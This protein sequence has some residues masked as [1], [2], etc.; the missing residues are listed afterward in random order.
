VRKLLSVRWLTA[1]LLIVLLSI[2]CVQLGR[3]QLHRLDERKA[4]NEVTRAN[5]AAPPV[6]VTEVVGPDRVVGAAHDWRT[7]VA[8]GR[9]DET[10]QIVIRYRNV[11]DRP[12]FEI[13]TPLVLAD[14]TAVLVDRGFLPRG[15]DSSAVPP[16]PPAPAGEVTVTGRL[17]RSERG[18]DTNGTMPVDGSARLINGA[19]IAGA[20]GLRAIDG[21]LLAD[22]QQ[23]AA[24]PAFKTLPPPEIDSG[25]HFFYALQW[26]LFALLALGG[27]V[28]FTRGDVRGDSSD[29]PTGAGVDAD[30]PKREPAGTGS[31]DRGLRADRGHPDGRAGL[32]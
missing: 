18:G 7:A 31:P 14:G 22:Q 23:P 4:R 27:L 21:Y 6:P 20:T 1:A 2:T 9:Y 25:P 30:G 3:W 10:R 32:D 19:A 24:D 13:V 29:A 8:T 17:R 26:F 12:G 11:G 5:L 16:V 15:T 28:Y